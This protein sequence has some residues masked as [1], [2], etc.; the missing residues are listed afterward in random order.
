MSS[1][2]VF[3]I[4]IALGA[5]AVACTGEPTDPGTPPP[6]PGSVQRWSDPATWPGRTL[7][8]AGV[9]VTI[10]AGTTVL[11]DL[12]P[13]S[14][15][16]LTVE[17]TLRLDDTRDVDL[18]AGWIIVHGRFEAGSESQPFTRRAVI[19]LAGD[20][21][22]EIMGMGARVFGV[23]G[24]TLELHGEKRSGWTRLSAT[25]NAGATQIT[26]ER[27]MP[28]RAGDRIALA[29]TDLSPLQAEEAVITAVQGAQLTLQA[30]LRYAHWG[31][32]QS[33]AG[34]TLDERAEVGLLSRNIVVRGDS[35]SLVTGIG[36]HLM[37]M[38]GGVAR[39]EG[40]ELTRMGQRKTLARYPMHWHLRGSVA[41]QYFRDNSVWKT[42][43]RCVTVHGTDDAVVQGNVCYDNLGH[44]IFLE[45]GAESGNLI[46]GNLGLLTRRPAAADQLLPSDNTPATYWLTHPANTV[47]G[48]V[49][50]GSQGFGF[51]YAFP[52]SP[53][54]LSIGAPDLPRQTP[55]GEFSGNVAH[56]NSNTGLNV[57]H[58][59]RPDGTIETVHYS[60]RQ[61]PGTSS[62][63]VT[64]VFRGFTGYKHPGR[65]VWL[66][67]T[68]LRLTESILADNAIGATFA[69]N[70]TFVTDAVF[71]GQSAN[72]GGTQIPTT[73][74]IRG[75]EFYDGR[76]GA[77][78]VTFVN[79][80]TGG[81]IMSAL[82]FNRSNGFPV[83]TG[84]YARSL[85]FQNANAVYLENPAPT[86]DGD[87]AAVI[88][89]T[90]GTL[91]G[92]A[93]AFVAA[94]NPL[95]LTPACVRRDLWNSWVCSSP[96]VQLQ[97]RGA[98]AQVVAPLRL[99]RDDAVA[100][101]FV[102]VPNNPQVVSASLVP[103]RS[104]AVQ[105][106][107]GV[108]DRPQFYL[109]RTTPGDWVRLTLP[110]PSP[111]LSVY[112]DYATSTPLPA[113]ASL[114]ELD[115]ST[116]NRYYYDAGTG[117]LHLKMVT[118]TG[119]TYATLFVTP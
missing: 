107:A 85:T 62:P 31:V 41:G 12:S 86:K 32:M 63:A 80:P 81:R 18:T 55:L 105:Y 42:F 90:D 20:P 48:N 77:E 7:P 26:L 69:S 109:N 96:F 65:A 99:V 68:E 16:S 73:F 117:L 53:T 79:Y 119:R 106:Q 64:A 110:Y 75:Y 44:A 101:D 36:G 45:D 29:S 88:L 78:R 87:K 76:V 100:G 91:T 49:A 11:L 43:N 104:Y 2:L 5:L 6:P 19:T 24:G 71:V 9:A 102:G 103:G 38:Q 98:N 13:P 83:S 82:G 10:P 108:P 84:N 57:D 37:V 14:L 58:G 17:G 97:V 27:A 35:G 22:D 92:S 59:P 25:A 113:A 112:R 30:P 40:V 8:A 93:G 3:R 51:W 1:S 61:V 94:N 39:I 67:G 72:G 23:M 115:A 54:G 50:A 118:Q 89:D 15:A 33:Y 56:S 60:P 21:A 95:L 34:R 4:G 116:G 47:R 70:E 52:A 46:E 74:P 114:A 111:A 28:W 66:R